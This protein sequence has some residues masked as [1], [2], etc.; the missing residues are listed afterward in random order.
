[1]MIE[2]LILL[3]VF[4]L[5]AERVA[6]WFWAEN[7]APRIRLDLWHHSASPKPAPPEEFS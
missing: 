1:M 6:S 3:G 2:A 7:D 4:G 5:L